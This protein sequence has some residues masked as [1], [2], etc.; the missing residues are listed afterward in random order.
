MVKETIFIFLTADH[1]AMDT[2]SMAREHKLPEGGLENYK[3]LESLKNLV[4]TKYGTDKL[5]ENYSNKQIFLN[6][7]LI[8]EKNLN[9]HEIQETIADYLRINIPDISVISTRDQLEGKFATREPINLILNGYQPSISGDIVFEVKPGFLP[10]RLEKGTTHGSS[11]TYDTHVPLIF[12]GWRVPK[13]TINAPVYTVDIA[14]TIAN[15][16]KITEP[17][18]CLGI[19]LIK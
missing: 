6:R 8:T 1:A 9:M 17:N 12:F 15:L 7:N 4:L 11:Y 5:I 2:P 13:Q 10:R 18:A 3:I 14:A 19:P 16:L